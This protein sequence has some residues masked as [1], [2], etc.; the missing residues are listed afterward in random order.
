MGDTIRLANFHVL[1]SCEGLAKDVE[2]KPKEE[3]WRSYIGL[4]ARQLL[5]KVM[6][7]K[8]EGIIHIWLSLMSLFSSVDVD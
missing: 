5:A 6:C 1:M 8:E 3:S 2:S 7:L 4:W